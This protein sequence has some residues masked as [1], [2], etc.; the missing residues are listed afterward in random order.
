[1]TQWTIIRDL[2]ADTKAPKGSNFNA[3]GI[4]GPKGATLTAQAIQNHSQSK[5]F[6]MLDDDGEVYYEGFVVGENPSAP[7]TDFGTPNAG[8]TTIQYFMDGKWETL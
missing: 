5:L 6:R 7:L 8:C 3:V 1:M 4:V 2:I